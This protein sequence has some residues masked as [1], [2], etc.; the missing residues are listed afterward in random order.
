MKQRKAQ[1]KIE[2]TSIWQ[3]GA[4][5]KENKDG[6]QDISNHL[7]SSTGVQPTLTTLSLCFFSL[8][9]P[10]VYKTRLF[11]IQIQATVIKFL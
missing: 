5:G 3:V 11:N 7:L 4:R 10:V 9:S 6:E 8:H 1:G 2:T